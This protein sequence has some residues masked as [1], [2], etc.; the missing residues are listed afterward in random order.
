[1]KHHS[2]HREQWLFKYKIHKQKI[3]KK[4]KKQT[5]NILPPKKNPPTV[6]KKKKKTNQ[7][8]IK[9]YFELDVV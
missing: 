4:P 5:K 8:N 7:K 6:Y 3:I 9:K 1:M 2:I